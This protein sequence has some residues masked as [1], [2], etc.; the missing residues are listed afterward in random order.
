MGLCEALK[1]SVFVPKGRIS[2]E[3]A[4]LDGFTARANSEL[5]LYTHAGGEGQYQARA[6]RP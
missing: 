4:A 5:R 1:A 2:P 6:Y 3:D